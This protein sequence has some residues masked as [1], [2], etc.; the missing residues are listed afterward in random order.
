MQSWVLIGEKVLEK[1][2]KSFEMLSVTKHLILIRP[3]HFHMKTMRRLETKLES[4]CLI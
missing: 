1:S 3:L 2:W 4:G